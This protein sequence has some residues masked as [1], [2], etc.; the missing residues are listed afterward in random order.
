[1]LFNESPSKVSL[2][3]METPDPILVNEIVC[4]DPSGLRF[5]HGGSQLHLETQRLSM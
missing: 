2:A 3:L 1:M 4:S 5:T